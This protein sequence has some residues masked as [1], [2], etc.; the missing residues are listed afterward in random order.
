[1]L[2]AQN[3]EWTGKLGNFLAGG[4]V[5]HLMASVTL[6]VSEEHLVF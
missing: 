4:A 5:R 3:V 6:C 1:M 2:L